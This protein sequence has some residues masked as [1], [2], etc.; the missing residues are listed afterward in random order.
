[1]LRNNAGGI[2]LP[3]ARLARK[4]NDKQPIPVLEK[5]SPI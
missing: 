2:G 5:G 4:D 1:M 3:V